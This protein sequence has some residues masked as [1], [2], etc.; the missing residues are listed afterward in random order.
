MKRSKVLKI[1][2]IVLRK[3][4]GPLSSHEIFENAKKMGFLSDHKILMGKTPWLSISSLIYVD[5]RYNTDTIFFQYSKRPTTF[6]LKKKLLK[7][8]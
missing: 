4:G 2:E 6:S 8:A 1:A 3:N 7:I 5:M